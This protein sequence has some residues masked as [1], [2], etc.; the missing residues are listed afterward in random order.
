MALEDAL[1]GAAAE[2]VRTIQREI[3]AQQG[4]LGDPLW[5]PFAMARR[6]QLE[7]QRVV[8]EIS[9][10]AAQE[11][12]ATA[13]AAF[14]KEI[15]GTIPGTLKQLATKAAQTPLTERTR[16][17][18]LSLVLLVAALAMVTG[19]FWGQVYNPSPYPKDI[20]D[21]LSNGNLPE[22]LRCKE[23]ISSSPT[24]PRKA[25][26][27][28]IWAEPASA[29]SAN[30]PIA[31]VTLGIIPAWMQ[32]IVAGLIA[33]IAVIAIVVSIFNNIVGTGDL[34]KDSTGR[35]GIW[36]VGGVVLLWLWRHVEPWW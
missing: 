13:V 26:S 22:F 3:L 5:V 33:V 10:K 19:A 30:G 29:P 27:I 9:A 6:A 12:A 17:V 34:W 28:R 24:E 2:D 25:C 15:Q 36:F 1:I 31:S 35:M 20:A 4:N 21:F 32:W 18:T 11:A 23:K 8:P 14:H 16:Q 7:T